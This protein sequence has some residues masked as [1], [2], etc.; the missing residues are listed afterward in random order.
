MR[1]MLM[2]LRDD[3]YRKVLSGEKIYE[4]RKV[5]PDEPVKAYIYV[6][7]PTKAICGIMY[8][9]NRTSLLKWK[10]QYKG[11]I[12]CVKR[13]NEYLS[14]HNYAMEIN[15]FERTNSIGLEQLRAE[16]SKFVVPQMYYYIENT[17][18]LAY[19]EE[20]LAVDGFVVTHEY[21]SIDS[22]MICKA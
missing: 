22:S 18:L 6:S 20:K 14:H 3:V 17:E 19:L 21:D 2:S 13:I 10:E 12:D 9:S 15:K 16:L 7:A 4:H 5:F 11:D 1:I 8:L